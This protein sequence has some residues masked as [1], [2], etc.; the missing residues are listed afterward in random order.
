MKPKQKDFQEIKGIKQLIT[1]INSDYKFSLDYRIC[2]DIDDGSFEA[3]VEGNDDIAI[4]QAKTYVGS[5]AELKA[6]LKAF[7]NSVRDSYK[8]FEHIT[9]PIDKEEAVIEKFLN[10]KRKK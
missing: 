5:L 2:I 6:K 10:R 1:S 3:Y 8:N 4:G 7:R 9:D